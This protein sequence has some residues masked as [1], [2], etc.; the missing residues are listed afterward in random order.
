M[1]ENGVSIAGTP[2]IPIVKLI[3][4]GGGSANFREAASRLIKQ[5]EDF[6]SIDVRRAYTETDLPSDYHK[7]FNGLLESH[8]A[9]Y[10][11]YSWKPYLVYN[12][13]L[14]LNQN[15]I[16]IYID[17]GCELNKFG[18]RRFDD[19]LSYTSKNDVLLFEL[20]HPNRYWTKFHPMLLGYPEHY[21]RNQL[22]ASVIFLK[23]NDRTKQFIKSWLDLCAFENGILLKDPEENE[24]QLPIFK[25][26]RQ[27]QS[28]LSICAYLHNIR[29]ISDETWFQDW[30][31]AEKFPILAL[32]SRT[33]VSVLNEKLRKNI[34]RRAKLSFKEWRRKIKHKKAR[35]QK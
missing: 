33:G 11:L 22:V 28:C 13:L 7:L 25:M 9:G 19:Y 16:L 6:P 26:H 27:D 5:S 17:A 4:F 30:R 24:L 31:N 20:Q 18:I 21:F 14:M 32:R 12:E 23:N 15:D 1:K 29:T 34:F 3:T 35:N 8:P 2:K 10:G